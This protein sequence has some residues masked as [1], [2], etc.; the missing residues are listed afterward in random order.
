MRF[1]QQEVAKS[2]WLSAYQ[3]KGCSQALNIVTYHCHL[4]LHHYAL[5]LRVI[6]KGPVHMVTGCPMGCIWGVYV[7]LC[8]P[9]TLS[10]MVVHRTLSE[11]HKQL[12]PQKKKNFKD[13]NLRSSPLFNLV[14]H[15][16]KKCP[17][18]QN[19][20]KSSVFFYSFLQL[21]ACALLFLLFTLSHM[22]PDRAV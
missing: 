6:V 3:C 8:N 13:Q 1:F 20:H 12:R 10:F 16:F 18:W 2:S 21:L 14:L 11:G 4:P 9:G 15:W 19:L 5:W 22:A 17:T 7:T